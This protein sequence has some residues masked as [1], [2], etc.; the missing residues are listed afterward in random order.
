MLH[1]GR[2]SN[3]GAADIV[4]HSCTQQVPRVDVN[5]PHTHTH[6]Q[7]RG[8]AIDR[9]SINNMSFS[10]KEQHREGGLFPSVWVQQPPP[11]SKQKKGKEMSSPARFHSPEIFPT[12]SRTI[13]M[14][15]YNSET[16]NKSP[17]R[18]TAAVPSLYFSCAGP[19]VEL[20]SPSI[21]LV[22]SF[23]MCIYRL[24]AAVHQIGNGE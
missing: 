11:L 15:G 17:S 13:P 3:V 20:Q 19:L 22:L 1:I 7:E 10:Y 5:T 16:R 8:A 23:S 18:C 12:R 21:S 6:G 2:E 4:L 9:N 24:L 14:D